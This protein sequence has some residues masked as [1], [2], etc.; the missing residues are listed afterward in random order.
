MTSDGGCCGHDRADEMGA[1]VFALAAFEIAIA[2]AGAALMRRENVGIHPD[3]HAAARVAPLENGG[4]KNFVAAFFLGL[5]LYRARA[6][7]AHWFVYT[8]FDVLG[9]DRVGACAPGNVA[10]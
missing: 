8:F 5:R 1:A 10:G 6:T 9:F 3:A 4:G 2:G 7:D